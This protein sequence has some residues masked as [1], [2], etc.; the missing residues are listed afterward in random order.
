MIY[1]K[2][3]TIASLAL[4]FTLLAGFIVWANI[5]SNDIVGLREVLA[6]R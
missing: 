6:A 1:Y 3:I 5:E 2:S 4:L